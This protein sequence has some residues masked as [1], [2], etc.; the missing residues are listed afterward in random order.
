L[1]QVAR[2]SD[3]EISSL[4][5]SPDGNLLTWVT[6]DGFALHLWDVS[7]SRSYPFPPL[8]VNG[9]VR[10]TAFCSDSKHLA[11]IRHGGVPEVWNVDTRERVY[12]S[13][14]DDFRGASEQNLICVVALSADDAWLATQGTRGVTVW[15]MR[16][17][18]LLLALPEEHDISWG[19]AWSPN[20]ELLAASFSDGTLVI[21]N[22]PRVRALLAEIGLDWQDPPS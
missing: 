2:P 14:P 19:L 18:E 13:G 20:R 5:F 21:W 16:R 17:R 8:N 11:F 4:S 3:R 9:S 7:R 22:I 10:N 12:P 6:Y 1:Q 15:D